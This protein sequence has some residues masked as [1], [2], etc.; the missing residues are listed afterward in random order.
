[1]H[2]SSSKSAQQT[3]EDR[4]PR[5]CEA[6]AWSRPRCELAFYFWYYPPTGWVFYWRVAAV[7]VVFSMICHNHF[8]WSSSV[9]F[10][11][12]SHS[13]SSLPLL[14]LVFLGQ[15]KLLV[16]LALHHSKW[17]SLKLCGWHSRAPAFRFVD[18]P[19]IVRKNDSWTL[20]KGYN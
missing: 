18:A 5:H 17:H 7:H 15:H 4:F 8:L 13:L 9:S 11:S 14:P 6:A 1:M 16:V 12:L 10:S 19:S 2:N 20:A 3:L